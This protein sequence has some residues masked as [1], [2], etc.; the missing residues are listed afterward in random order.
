MKDWTAELAINASN[1]MFARMEG[2]PFKTQS[3]YQFQNSIISFRLHIFQLEEKLHA[4]SL[5]RK[6][7][8]FLQIFSAAL[9]NFILSEYLS[10]MVK[11]VRCHI[12]SGFLAKIKSREQYGTLQRYT[13]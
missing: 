10:Q 4:Y 9:L 2:K 1:V 5:K 13:F 7:K 12:C 11:L 6:F 8:I 3:R